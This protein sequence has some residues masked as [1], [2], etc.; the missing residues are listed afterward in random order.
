MWLLKYS[1]AFAL[2]RSVFLVYPMLLGFPALCAYGF[3]PLLE[4]EL[5]E[6]KGNTCLFYFSVALGLHC[7]MW[8]F[9]S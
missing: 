9:T 1:P 8:A 7:C 4:Y 2:D 5:T 3:S 6:G